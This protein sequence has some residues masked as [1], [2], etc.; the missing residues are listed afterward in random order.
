MADNESN[1]SSNSGMG[2]LIGA[3]LVIVIILLIVIYGL[4]R[5]TNIDNSPD[6]GVPEE[7]DVNINQPGTG[8]NQGE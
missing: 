2:I 1:A 5:L 3:L 7:V 6:I 4:P 8:N